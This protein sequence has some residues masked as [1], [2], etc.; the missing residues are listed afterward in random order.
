[1]EQ[2]RVGPWIIPLLH[3]TLIPGYCPVGPATIQHFYSGVNGSRSTQER[4]GLNF[5]GSANPGYFSGGPFTP[6]SGPV[7]NRVDAAV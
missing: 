1:M 3:H 2:S 5:A 7:I 4:P 6:E